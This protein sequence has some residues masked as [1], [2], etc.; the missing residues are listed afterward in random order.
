MKANSWTLEKVQSWLRDHPQYVRQS[1]PQP[2]S[3]SV[4]IQPTNIA[5]EQRK[6]ALA[7]AILP[8]ET[9]QLLSPSGLVS[10]RE[11][12]ELLPERVPIHWGYGPAELVR[13]LKSKLE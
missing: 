7:E 6:P 11:I 9:E 1:Q 8:S 10:K 12:L 2:V 13:R 3:A 5:I 4:G